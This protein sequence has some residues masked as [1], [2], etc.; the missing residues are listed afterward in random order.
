MFRWLTR[1][2][3]LRF[4]PRRLVP[5]LTVI[6]LVRLARGLRRSRYAVNE[7]TDSRTAPP[8][9]ISAPG[10]ES[11]APVGQGDQAETGG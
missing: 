5:I 9:K 3:L 7:P 11:V 2:F 10:G 4:L 6:E 1:F 8:P